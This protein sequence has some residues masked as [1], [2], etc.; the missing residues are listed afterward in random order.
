MANQRLT[1]SLVLMDQG[2]TLLQWVSKY[3]GE[4]TDYTYKVN[5]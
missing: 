4:W 5:V 1:L 3:E 2:A